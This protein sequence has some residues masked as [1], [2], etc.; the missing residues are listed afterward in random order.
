MIH[1]TTLARVLSVA[2]LSLGLAA[3]A[4]ATDAARPGLLGARYAAAGYSY[5]DVADTGYDARNYAFEYNQGVTAHLDA[6]LELDYL[7]SEG[8]GGAT[9]SGQH[10]TFKSAALAARAHTDWSGVRP[11][12]ELGAGGVWFRAPLGIQD[13]SFAWFAGVGVE[14]TLTERGVVT[15]IVRYTDAVDFA[16]GGTWDFGVRAHY[17]LS[18]RAALTA[19]LGRDDDQNTEYQ[20]GVA[21]RF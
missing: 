20:L 11:F 17:W 15:P 12:A 8:L 16:T 9:F 14:W 4:S 19:T 13:E 1:S 2:A 5:V 21:F 10:Y 18:D 7:R 6:R 3:A